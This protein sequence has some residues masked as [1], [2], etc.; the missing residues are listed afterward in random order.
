MNHITLRN[1][2]IESAIKKHG[3]II[4]G[5]SNFAYS[6]GM[7]NYGLPEIIITTMSQRTQAYLINH[8]F[9]KWLEEGVD[10]KSVEPMFG[11]ARWFRCSDEVRKAKCK[12]RA[13][14]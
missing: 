5:V 8:F 14:R 7:T 2:Q 13:N 11:K 12:W 9:H 6:T 1:M 4:H 3:I 10:L